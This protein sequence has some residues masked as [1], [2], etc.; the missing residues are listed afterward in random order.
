MGKA[1]STKSDLAK[2]IKQATNKYITNISETN[3]NHIA[4][5]DHTT[6][7]IN[8]E[9]NRFGH[10]NF[11]TDIPVCDNL[12]FLNKKVKELDLENAN[13][14]FNKLLEKL[15]TKNNK[16]KSNEFLLKLYI[17]NQDNVTISA[18]QLNILAN[19]CNKFHYQIPSHIQLQL[20]DTTITKN[21][22]VLA[23]K[24]AKETRART[25]II[26]E[27]DFKSFTKDY[28]QATN[29]KKNRSEE[30]D[31]DNDL[32]KKKPQ[33]FSKKPK[34]SQ[35]D[36]DKYIIA[37]TISQLQEKYFSANCEGSCWVTK[38]GHIKLSGMHYTT[39][40]RAIINR[41]ADIDTPP[42]HTIF[43]SPSKVRGISNSNQSPLQPLLQPTSSQI[44]SQMH[45]QIPSQMSLQMLLSQIDSQIP[46]QMPLQIPS[47]PSS[48][49]PSNFLNYL[50]Q[51][52]TNFFSHYSNIPLTVL[53]NFSLYIPSNFSSQLLSSISSQPYFMLFPILSNL[54]QESTTSSRCIPEL[55]EFLTNMDKAK[56]ANG[57]ILVCLLKFQDHAIQVKQICKLNDK[58]FE[59]VG[60]TKTG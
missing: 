28:N 56:N 26:D 49:M 19:S 32:N 55:K 50:L 18:K 29:K 47:Q 11:N 37:S 57:E 43:I 40:A 6:F 60:I 7:N 3:N 33:L 13:S 30:P 58:Q 22:Y 8:I 54:S 38:T 17:K 25:Q 21:D 36:D 51:L 39:W 34:E 59:L 5:N 27:K 24:V 23:Y 44:P 10:T 14:D 53:P 12:D 20:N 35:L 15:D 46:M 41:L 16:Y 42:S 52:S 2:P 48:Q 45:L 9:T 1:K 4:F 31:S